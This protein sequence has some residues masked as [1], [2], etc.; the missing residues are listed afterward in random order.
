MSGTESG[1]REDSTVARPAPWP[2]VTFGIIVLNGLPFLEPNLRSLY[3]FAHQIVVVEGASPAAAGFARSDG[4]SSDGTLERLRAFRAEQDPQDKV[5]IVTAEDEGHTDGFWPG[6]KDEQSR[7]YAAR[8]TG[9]YLWQVDVDEFY[10]PEAMATMLG[11][12]GEEPRVAAASFRMV[13]FWGSPDVVADGWHL[14]R[15]G[16]VYHRLFRWGPGYSYARHRPPTVLDQNGNDLRTGAPDGDGPDADLADLPAAASAVD[17]VWLDVGATERLG[18]KLLHY[19]LLFP[20]QVREKVEYYVNWDVSPSWFA[21]ARRWMADSYLT[22]RRPFRVHNVYRSPSWLDRYSGEHPAE[23]SRMLAEV[24]EA[25]PGT[26]LAEELRGEA[27]VRRLL[28]A[29]WYNAGRAA[30]RAAEPVERAT[31]EQWRRAR[32]L[33]DRVAARARPPLGRAA[34][35]VGAAPGVDGV[36]G[37]AERATGRVSRGVRRRA[38]AARERAMPGA[39]ILAYHRVAAPSGDP[40]A[41]CVSPD[42]FAAHLEVLREMGSCVRMRD[43][44]RRMAVAQVPRRTIVVTF[45]DGYADNLHAAEPLLRAAGV[46]ATMFVSTGGL[47]EAAPFWWDELASL[48]LPRAVESAGA[49]GPDDDRGERWDLRRRDDP[50]PAHAEYRRVAAELRLLDDEGR[51]RALAGLRATHGGPGEG[52]ALMT[53][54]EV[55]A[56]SRSD[57]IDVGSHCVTHTLL[58][59][60]APDDV[61]GEFLASKA[62]LQELTGRGCDLLSYPFGGHGD[63]PDVAPAV[64]HDCGY[65]AACANVP[66]TVWSGSDP[67]RLP[68]LLVR[69]WT[70]GELGDRLERWFSGE[71]EGAW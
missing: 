25:A 4:H 5:E 57:V 50:T 22:L 8:A 10:L 14:R 18:V 46:P 38:T 63:V 41:M 66:G 44:V 29:S 37:L 26:G 9:D 21:E 32:R 47:G 17:G 11:R 2:R 54:E 49:P 51:T 64:A 7:A 70:P 40:Q 27:D 28:D 33:A 56:L 71:V 55:A 69:D 59:A 1:V 52:P 3:P 36:R 19:S 67:Y 35:A 61:R 42:R 45:D 15:G 58:T 62:R 30:V 39:V 16:N 20:R 65:M 23:I 68:R 60:L 6:E 53:G 13:T 24:R 31:G 12:L 43:L 48:L 34:A